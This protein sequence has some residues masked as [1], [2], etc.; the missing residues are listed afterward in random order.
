MQSALLAVL[1]A[2]GLLGVGGT[3][4][5]AMS[6]GPMISGGGGMGGMGDMGDMGDMDY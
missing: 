6:G 3:A 5:V 1:L 4:A 2:A